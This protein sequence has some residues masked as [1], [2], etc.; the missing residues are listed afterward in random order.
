[1]RPHQLYHR[2]SGE[3]ETYSALAVQH[4]MNPHNA[5]R[6]EQADGRGCTTSA[7]VEDYVEIS[8][9]VDEASR[10]IT[11]IRFRA[12]GSPAVLACA[13]LLTDLVGGQSLDAAVALQPL[14]LEQ[15]L[16]GLPE[17][18]RLCAELPLRALRAAVEDYE[19]RQA[20]LNLRLR[21]EQLNA[22][23]TL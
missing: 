13:S 22:D 4:F 2:D 6:L 11:E 16:G 7:T 18:K 14:D 5:G 8:L 20:L 17:K 1:M 21:S 12:V 23:S 15:A 19:Q 3:F 9:R 10:V